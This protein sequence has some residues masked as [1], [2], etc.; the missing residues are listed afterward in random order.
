[1]ADVENRSTAAHAMPTAVIN[2]SLLLFF[3]VMLSNLDTVQ[4]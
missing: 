1:M 3:M 4:P 2:D